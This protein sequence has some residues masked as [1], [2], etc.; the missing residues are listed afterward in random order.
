MKN[1]R[2]LKT[3]LWL[4]LFMLIGASAYGQGYYQMQENDAPLE[5]LSKEIFEERFGNNIH[6]PRTEREIVALAHDLYPSLE[7]KASLPDKMYDEITE[8]SE[9]WCGEEKVGLLFAAL[10]NPEITNYTR[11][12]VSEIIDASIPVLPKTKTSASGRF[13]IWYTTNNADS[14]HNVTDAQINT[15]ATLLDSYWNSYTKNFKEPKHKIENGKKRIDVKVY[16]IDAYTL[17]VTSSYWDYMALNSASCV[18]DACKRR[19]TS[20][21]ELFHRVQYAYGY[22]SGTA[23]MSW[24]VEGTASWSQKFT[25]QTIRDYMARMHTGLG[26]P[27][28]GLFTRSYD[29]CHFWVYLHEQSTASAIKQVWAKYQANGKKAKEAV[30]SVTSNRLGLNFDKYTAKWSKA[31]YMKDLKNATTNGYNY[32]EN[33]VSTTSCGVAYGPLRKVPV[34]TK[35]INQ[36]SGFKQTGSVSPYGAKYH[37]FTLGKTLKN[38]SINFKGTGSFEIAFIGIKNNE[39]KSITDKTLTSYNYKKTLTAGQWD[40]LAVMV[41]GT[42][43]GGSYSLQIGGCITGTWKDQWYTWE[44]TEEGSKIKGKVYGTCGGTRNVSGTIKD[45]KITLNAPY[46]GTSCCAFTYNGTVTGCNKISGTWK[47]T[48]GATGCTYTGT[49][50]M[51]KQN[52]GSSNSGYEIQSEGGGPSCCSD[53]CN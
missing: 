18:R 32:L 2:R 8:E 39:W 49:F 5:I 35:T 15:L 47:Q 13:K 9:N 44:L 31:N 37:V 45:N 16:Y 6:I 33:T 22:I 25:N 34:T 24:I 10:Q 12:M 23:N 19:T 38:L 51:T 1:I 53:M 4:I 46:T 11:K 48:G 43:K 28:K 52:S 3:F 42:S 21:H 20:A 27:G 7:Y 41:M 50:S 40:K 36:D 17:G 30:G 29:A 14:K 26:D